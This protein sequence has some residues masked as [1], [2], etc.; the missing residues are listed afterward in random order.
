[1]REALVTTD[2][3]LVKLLEADE[4][5]GDYE[6]LQLEVKRSRR[7]IRANRDLRSGGDLE[8]PDRAGV[9]FQDFRAICSTRSSSDSCP[10]PSA[11][12]RR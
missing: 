12:R 9:S 2:R 6:S 4:G 8:L 10:E 5:F 3:C 11:S 7:Q 1:V